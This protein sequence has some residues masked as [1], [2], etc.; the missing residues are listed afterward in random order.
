MVSASGGMDAPEKEYT[1]QPLI[2]SIKTEKIT[3]NIPT[4]LLLIVVSLLN[5]VF[6]NFTVK[7]SF[8]NPELFSCAL[9]SPL[10]LIQSA[11]DHILLFL[12]E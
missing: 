6:L 12:L 4:A 7:C 2:V 1:P 11:T 9:P 3:I 8:G 5:I 10:V